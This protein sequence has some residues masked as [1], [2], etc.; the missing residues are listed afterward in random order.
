[1]RIAQVTG[2]WM[3]V[4]PLH[5]GGTTRI[6]SLLTEEL[7]KRG[8][9][10]TLF[11]TGESNTRANLRAA[12][13]RSLADAYA[14]SEIGRFD[15]YRMSNLADAVAE[16]GSFDVIHCHMGPFS[17]PFSQLS[18]VP[19]IH[20]IMDRLDQDDV[21]MLNRYPD[22]PVIARSHRQIAE[23]PT[24]RRRTINVIYNGHDFG[25]YDLVERPGRY[26]AFLGRMSPDKGAVQAIQIAAKAGM[27]IV[28]AGEPMFDFEVTYF[29]EEVRPLIDGTNVTWI[30]PVDN[31]AKKTLLENA[32]A[33][34]FPIRWEEPFGNVMV[35]A[36]A[37]G[38][39]VVATSRGSVPE[40]VDPGITGF[41]ADSDDE[42]PAL[43][44]RAVAL[45]RRSV[46][47]AARRRFDHRLMVDQY[48]A[49]YCAA[50]SGQHARSN[51]AAPDH[52]AG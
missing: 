33:L 16:T 39:P 3:N 43:V 46:R 14:N 50:I 49:A 30:G 13:P 6:V 23:L 34:L 1:M 44:A 12:Y 10:V 26:L 41:Y 29:E 45:D 27:P 42:L 8:H 22:A 11:A 31:A 32:G 35:E 28:L 48:E 20:T 24:D 18:R 51:D 15:F 36:M 25:F 40:V 7:V 2:L 37:C 21:W 47:E 38:T 4:P 19:V 5:Y 17:M 52:H 9:D